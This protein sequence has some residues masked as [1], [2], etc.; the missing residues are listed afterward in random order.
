[1]ST[2]SGPSVVKLAAGALVA[3]A[4]NGK[5]GLPLTAPCV[6]ADVNN[7]GIDDI[8][9]PWGGVLPAGKTPDEDE[10]FRTPPSLLCW[11][12]LPGGWFGKYVESPLGKFLMNPNGATVADFDSDGLLDVLVSGTRGAA[13]ARSTGN[14]AFRTTVWAI[15]SALGET[16]LIGAVPCDLNLDGRL[17]LALR[18]NGQL[19]QFAV[20]SALNAYNQSTDLALRTAADPAKPTEKPWEMVCAKDLEGTQE[21]CAVADF[22][23]DGAEDVVMVGKGGKVW[24]LKSDGALHLGVSL[25]A[26]A[27]T[28]GPTR[29]VAFEGTRCLGA[30]L[31][32]PGMPAYLGKPNVSPVKLEWLAGGVAASKSVLVRKPT[33]VELTP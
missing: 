28:Y 27:T 1:M 6:V 5:A 19:P 29:V 30:R 32:Q 13:I 15:G 22:T 20:H 3:N 14:G 23:G 16:T 4:L 7:D 2:P 8:V 10:D 17:D 33:R 31:A 11:R 9:Q 12:G 25:A 18:Y 26:P 24:M 21:A